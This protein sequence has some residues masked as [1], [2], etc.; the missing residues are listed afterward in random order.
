MSAV[1]YELQILSSLFI[2]HTT[3]LSP[4]C[5]EIK[6]SWFLSA[7]VKGLSLKARECLLLLFTYE[8]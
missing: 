2:L 6:F 1:K 4:S 7:S 5:R 3:M 8:N